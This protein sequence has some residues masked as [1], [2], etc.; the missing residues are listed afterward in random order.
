MAC[1]RSRWKTVTGGQAVANPF[2]PAFFFPT[3]F[4]SGKIKNKEQEAQLSLSMTT[5]FENFLNYRDHEQRHL[6]ILN[7]VAMVM[8]SGI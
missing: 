6:K 2:S 1:R 4:F 8:E 5:T 3:N 7:P